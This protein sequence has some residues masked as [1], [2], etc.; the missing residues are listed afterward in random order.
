MNSGQECAGIPGMVSG[1]P[2][3]AIDVQKRILYPMTQ[4]IQMLVVIAE[5]CGFFVAGAQVSR[6]LPV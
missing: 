2:A 5:A 4:L 3:P 6:L 1:E